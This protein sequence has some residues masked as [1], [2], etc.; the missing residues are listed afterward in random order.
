VMTIMI[1]MT[2]QASRH[3]P[4]WPVAA[5]KTHFSAMIDR[6]LA[7]GP[8]MVTRRGKRTVVVVP[9]EEWERRSK[10]IGSLAEFFA[11]SPLRGSRLKVQ[12]ARDLPR[13]VGV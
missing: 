5:A 8:Q 11:A 7:E 12:R 6:A 1:I 13:D 9:A 3:G 4:E 10:R 2:N